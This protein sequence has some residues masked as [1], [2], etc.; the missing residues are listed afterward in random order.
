VAEPEPEPLSGPEPLEPAPMDGG[1]PAP[2]PGPAPAPELATDDDEFEDE[3]DAFDEDDELEDAEAPAGTR[4]VSGAE[5]SRVAPKRQVR[6]RHKRPP[7]SARAPGARRRRYAGRAG[8]LVA[9][10]LAG[11]LIWFL[12]ELFQPFHGSGHG[13]VT[14]TIPAHASSSTVGDLLEREGVI[15]SSFF[16]EARATLAG[17]RSDLRSG[18]YHLQQGMS[19]GSVLKILTTAPPAA[20]VTELTLTEGK[21]RRQV[22]TLL[23][24]QGVHGSYL[25]E[26]RR[27]PLLNPRRYGAPRS[28][29]SLE[30][31]LFP[32]TYQLREPIRISALVADQLRTFRQRFAHV[33]LGYARHAKLTAYDVLIIA[34]MVEGEAAT[35]R[36]RPL[37]ASVIYNRLKA[38]MPLQI[39]ATTRYATGNYTKPLTVSE[40]NSPSPYNTRIHKGLPPTPID[41]PGVAAIN[42]AAHPARTKDLF[43]VVKP[44]TC[45]QVFTP[46]YQQFL[47]YQQQYQAARSARGGRSPSR[48]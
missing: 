47:K 15:S 41:N 6:R 20:R 13:R 31:F 36:D 24:A 3:A 39:D 43:F 37:V 40:L 45:I 14:V 35:A 7:R 9:I 4:R 5:R 27:S 18:T 25:A 19:Y 17:E 2:E 11:A 42:A 16:F 32:E 23:R 21:T 44:G 1:E 29:P 22:D 38:G 34:S 30:G 10:V 28:T 12:I 8:S 46:S 26:T 48:C 33:N